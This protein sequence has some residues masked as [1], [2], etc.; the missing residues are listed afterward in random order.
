[1]KLETVGSIKGKI[2]LL[3]DDG[4]LLVHVVVW[5]WSGLVPIA[6]PA[7]GPLAGMIGSII[8]VVATVTL[9]AP[10]ATIDEPGNG[11]TPLVMIVR[12]EQDDLVFSVRATENEE[13][14]MVAAENFQLVGRVK[15]GKI[16]L[17][18]VQFG[19]STWTFGDACF[20]M[21]VLRHGFLQGITIP[22]GEPGVPWHMVPGVGVV[23]VTPGTHRHDGPGAAQLIFILDPDDALFVSAVLVKGTEAHIPLFLASTA[24]GGHSHQHNID[25]QSPVRVKFLVGI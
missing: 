15:A 20:S 10:I 6:G 7:S 22:K 2:T 16:L 21:K 23:A 24:R 4:R 5:T 12:L 25:L 19:E 18:P 3:A 13:E 11:G 1:M 8:R 14:G 17:E 9:M